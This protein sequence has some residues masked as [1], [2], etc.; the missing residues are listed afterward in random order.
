MR[1]GMETGVR[2]VSAAQSLQALLSI[3]LGPTYLCVL[4]GTTLQFQCHC[5]GDILLHHLHQQRYALCCIAR[6]T[7]QV[8]IQRADCIHQ[9]CDA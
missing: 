9:G 4:Q 6:I 8:Q 2:G 5:S 7:G 1:G 3:P